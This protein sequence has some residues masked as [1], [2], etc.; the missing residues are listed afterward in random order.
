M[1]FKQRDKQKFYYI[2]LPSIIKIIKK[3]KNKNKYLNNII[4]IINKIHC[5]KRNI[6]YY[7]RAFS[8]S[9]KK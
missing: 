5:I 1:I 3:N 2:L 6:L 7:Q 4:N 9:F 8:V